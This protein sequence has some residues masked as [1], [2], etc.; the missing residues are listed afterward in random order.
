MPS[1]TAEGSTLFLFL[2]LS[3]FF[4]EK[5]DL[6]FYAN[7]LLSRWFAWNV[8]SYFLRKLK[9]TIQ[10]V[11]CYW[12]DWHF[13]SQNIRR[14]CFEKYLIT[15]LKTVWFEIFVTKARNA[16]AYFPLE[17]KGYIMYHN[18]TEFKVCSILCLRLC[19]HYKCVEYKVL[20]FMLGYPLEH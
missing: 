13:E 11:I 15:F 14:H 17:T 18:G 3:L 7:H 12:C 2:L 6:T 10:N 19:G 5:K 4:K 1:K 16:Q 9:K 8:K 20:C